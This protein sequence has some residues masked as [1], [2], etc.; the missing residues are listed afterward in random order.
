MPLGSWDSVLSGKVFF[1]N[2]LFCFLAFCRVCVLACLLSALLLWMKTPAFPDSP[3]FQILQFSEKGLP[4]LQGPLAP[5]APGH[6]VLQPWPVRK[7]RWPVPEG[8]GRLG[9]PL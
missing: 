4:V 8:D 1:F 7:A 6:G 2:L 5:Q 9:R 3:W